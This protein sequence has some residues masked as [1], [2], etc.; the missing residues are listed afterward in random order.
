M[1]FSPLAQKNCIIQGLENIDLIARCVAQLIEAIIDVHSVR[2]EQFHLIG[3]STGAHIAAQTRWYLRGPIF[4]I[5]GKNYA[6]F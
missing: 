6:G 5:T 2:R 4:R 3:H 1:D